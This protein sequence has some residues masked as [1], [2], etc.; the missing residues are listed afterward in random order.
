MRQ[1]A[2]DEHAQRRRAPSNR[3]LH[4][5]KGVMAESGAMGPFC[6]VNYSRKGEWLTARNTF[7][8]IRGNIDFIAK[9]RPAKNRPHSRHFWHRNTIPMQRGPFRA[10][11]ATDRVMP[12]TKN[13]SM[14]KSPSRKC[15]RYQTRERPWPTCATNTLAI[16][17]ERAPPGHWPDWARLV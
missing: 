9:S 11:P 3:P 17:I 2:G 15:N 7:C 5:S 4:P 8:L 1:T 12:R 6:K 14:D 13:R 16:N 10:F